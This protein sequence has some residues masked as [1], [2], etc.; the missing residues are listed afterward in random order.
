MAFLIFCISDT[1]V[2]LGLIGN[3]WP[4]VPGHEIIGDIV[5]VHPSVTE[6]KVGQRVGAPWRGGYCGHCQK[7]Q[8]GIFTAC[9]VG[10]TRTTGAQTPHRLRS[11]LTPAPGGFKDGGYS[12]YCLIDIEGICSIPTDVEPVEIA[13]MMCAGVTVYSALHP[14]LLASQL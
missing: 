10:P 13:P 7:C 8:A 2:Q 9:A 14:R 11:E 5:A 6:W 1:V 12:Q 3:P 4:R